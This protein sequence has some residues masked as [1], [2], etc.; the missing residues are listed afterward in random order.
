MK[1][2]HGRSAT[3]YFVKSL[4][5]LAV[6][7]V[8]L[9]HV[10]FK[11]SLK[12]SSSVAS[13]ISTTSLHSLMMSSGSSVSSSFV[14]RNNATRN[15]YVM[16]EN[17]EMPLGDSDDG[18]DDGNTKI[19]HKVARYR[20]NKCEYV[21]TNCNS[22]LAGGLINYLRIRYCTF[23]TVPFF[24]FVFAVSVIVLL[25]CSFINTRLI[26]DDSLCG[27]C[28]YSTCYQIRLRPISALR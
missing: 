22:P 18:D 8:T 20:N 23:S 16:M 14:S 1:L 17:A 24:F 19:C 27:F 4:V 3:W 13:S 28:F 12:A 9:L 26:L 2:V 25:N 5:I 11:Q 15:L 6:I 10:S 21:K 7:G